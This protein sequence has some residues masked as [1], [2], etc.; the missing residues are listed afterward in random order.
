MAPVQTFNDYG[1]P[2]FQYFLKHTPDRL[3]E[4]CFFFTQFLNIITL[5]KYWIATIILLS[6]SIAKYCKLIF[7]ERK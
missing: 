3:V 4:R 2:L 5:F 6:K 1:S 7:F